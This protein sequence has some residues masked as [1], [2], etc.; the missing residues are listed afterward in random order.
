ML[1]LEF[2]TLFYMER[3]FTSSNNHV[4]LRLTTATATVLEKSTIPCLEEYQQKPQQLARLSMLVL[5][6]VLVES[7]V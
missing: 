2:C 6:T 3:Q 1:Q 5:Q 7:L 4:K